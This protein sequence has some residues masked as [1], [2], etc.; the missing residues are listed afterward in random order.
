MNSSDTELTG[1]KKNQPMLFDGSDLKPESVSQS[2]PNF[3]ATESV[4]SNPSYKQSEIMFPRMPSLSDELSYEPKKI[5]NPMDEFLSFNNPS[6]NKQDKVDDSTNEGSDFKMH[7]DSYLNMV[8]MLNDNYPKIDLNGIAVDKPIDVVVGLPDNFVVRNYNL[9]DK[10]DNE[11][12]LSD[13]RFNN[14]FILNDSDFLTSSNLMTTKQLSEANANLITDQV[15]NLDFSNSSMYVNKNFP[16]LRAGGGKGDDYNFGNC[17]TLSLSYG[18]N[19]YCFMEEKNYENFD[20]GC[21]SIVE[22]SSSQE[23]NFEENSCLADIDLNLS[24]NLAY[25]NTEGKIIL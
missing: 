7:D 20:T 10:N 22:K 24:K 8:S 12:M 25:E 11:K 21:R 14:D 5:T 1:E 23:L 15:L 16:N 2:F 18:D 19:S 17:T 13:N 4:T 6:T 9:A 3:T